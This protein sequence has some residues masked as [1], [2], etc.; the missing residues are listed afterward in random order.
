[1]SRLER[2]EPATLQLLGFVLVSALLLSEVPTSRAC[3]PPQGEGEVRTSPE[4]LAYQSPIVVDA[5]V[6]ETLPPNP[7]SNR[8][9]ATFTIRN[10]KRN[11]FKGQLSGRS[12]VITVAQF[13]AEKSCVDLK[14]GQRYF[15]FLDPLEEGSD[16]YRVHYN[17]VL[18]NKK[19]QKKIKKAV[20]KGCAWAVLNKAQSVA[21]LRSAYSGRLRGSTPGPFQPPDYSATVYLFVYASPVATGDS[22]LNSS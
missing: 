14:K 2:L 16:V 8:Y 9:N 13:G 17:P 1:M 12:K 21:A 22:S 15:L 5:K 3:V 18:F 11:V 4:W 7:D 19:E 20:C 6:A 10:L